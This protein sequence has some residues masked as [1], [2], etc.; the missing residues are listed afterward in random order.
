MIIDGKAVNANTIL[1]NPS[2]YGKV[3]EL[4][5]ANNY[6]NNVNYVSEYLNDE[7]HD[8][9]IATSGYY[10]SITLPN[11]YELDASTLDNKFSEIKDGENRKNKYLNN[12]HLTEK[13]L[14]SVL[15]NFEGLDL[16]QS[17]RKTFS[18]IQFSDGLLEGNKPAP[19]N[20]LLNNPLAMLLFVLN[21]E[22]GAHVDYRDKGGYGNNLIGTK[23]NAVHSLDNATWGAEGKSEMELVTETLMAVSKYLESIKK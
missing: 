23:G 7:K 11:A 16:S 1:E 10:R 3:G 4:L 17:N 19:Y 6:M 9:Y 22:F 21:H 15:S 8:V 2:A 12:H 13:E 18:F 20:E 5:A 14:K